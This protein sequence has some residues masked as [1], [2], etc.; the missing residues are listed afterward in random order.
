MIRPG[1]LMD[2]EP[3]AHRRSAVNE[4]VQRL[5]Q[6]QEIEA[7]LRPEPTL[8]A[9]KAQVD[10]GYVHAKFPN[11]RGGTE[12]GIPLDR[13]RSDLSG[14]DFDQGTGHIKIVGELVLDYTRVRFHG[15]IDLATLKGTGHLE[16]LEDVQPGAA[17][18]A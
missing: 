8:S 12:L 9:L 14:A 10:R 6:E 11:T 2:L 5:T 1:K 17:T 18:T 3:S 13:T 15:T 16:P 7:S 4:L